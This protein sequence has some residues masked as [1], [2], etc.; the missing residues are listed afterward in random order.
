MQR[1]YQ[2]SG[3]DRILQKT[4]CTFDVSVWELF[5]PIISGATLVMA[6]PN[7]HLDHV[8]LA[9]FIDK[10]NITHVHFVP[11]VLDA[12]LEV[13]GA[14]PTSCRH[15]FCS[16][17]ALKAATARKFFVR[18][19]A[20][21]HN[22]YG[23][24]EASIDVT[25]YQVNRQSVVDPV[26]IGRP[27]D[28]IEIYV[29]DGQGRDVPVGAIGE[30]SIGGVGLALGYLNR[31]SLTEQKFVLRRLGSGY[32]R[33]YRTGDLGR[34]RE[35]GLIEYRG[36]ID[37]QVKV[38]GVRIELE[39]VEASLSS[40]PGVVAAAAQVRD[41]H[42]TGPRLVAYIVAAK[43]PELLMEE[44]RDHMAARLPDYMLPGQYFF[45][46]A[47]PL[48]PSGKVDRGVLRPRQLTHVDDV[49][50]RDSVERAIA[51]VWRVVLGVPGVGVHSDFVA[52]GGHSLAAIR[53][54]GLLRIE[55][56]IHASS[57]DVLETRTIAN[58]AE[59][60][61]SAANGTESAAPIDDSV[62]R[63]LR[64]S[65][66]RP[67]IVCVHPGGGGAHWYRHLAEHLPMSLPVVAI[68]HP[69]TIEYDYARL[70]ITHLANSYISRITA[71][72]ISSP[73]HLLGWCGGAPVAW[74]MGRLLTEDRAEVTLSLVDPTIDS[75]AHRD[76]VPQQ[77]LLL[78]RCRRLLEKLLHEDESAAT[79]PLRSEIVELLQRLVDNDRVR[80]LIRS[81]ALR[82]DWLRTVN[83]W[84][85]MA[86]AQHS[87]EFGSYAGRL[88]L[89]I[90][91]DIVAGTHESLGRNSYADYL[92]F[93]AARTSTPLG[94]RRVS[95][96]HLEVMMPPH[97]ATVAAVLDSISGRHG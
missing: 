75:T 4:I 28:N 3:A 35:D 60:I 65:G 36:R 66:S 93:W 30:I 25:F 56:G 37:N 67:P 33:I 5:W 72:G 74:E 69:A 86:E 31:T 54:S 43:D 23:P 76:D 57:R 88:E 52:L 62:V 14:F 9:E 61:S 21:L 58:L 55:H 45:L 95:G 63:W 20:E 1:R 8:A 2:I 80:R 7:A 27:I 91:D 40:C 49:N 47:L 89:L 51:S 17:E 94:V 53:A 16:G 10:T 46:P 34:W 18:S 78:R 64:R 84:L 90:G 81:D 50:P 32:R 42:D 82:P 85:Y 38:H 39:E 44:I 68:Q 96:G 97:V 19:S 12:F 11:S 24:T 70:P 29:L 59:R 15:V 13:N 87:Y 48:T 6:P 22:L 79:G 92:R 71:A 77:L 73:F 83:V 26:P 41:D